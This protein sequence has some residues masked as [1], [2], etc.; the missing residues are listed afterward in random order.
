VFGEL[1][2]SPGVHL[3]NVGRVHRDGQPDPVAAYFLVSDFGSDPVVTEILG[4]KRQQSDA[5]T[6]PNLSLIETLE[7]DPQRIKKL[8]ASYLAQIGVQKEKHE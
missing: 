3:Q 7:A 6:D 5:I 4:L 8:A 1:D 2:W